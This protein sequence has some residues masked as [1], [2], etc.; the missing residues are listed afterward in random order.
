VPLYTRH[1]QGTIAAERERRRSTHTGALLRF[2]GPPAKPHPRLAT[3]IAAQRR[4]GTQTLADENRWI[5]EG[6]RFDPEAVGL[7]RIGNRKMK[8][9]SS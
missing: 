4:R 9:C 7:L 6:G 8:R 2:A 3:A 1:T 5:D